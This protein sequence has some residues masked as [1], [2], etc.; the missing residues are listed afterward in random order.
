MALEI[1]DINLGGTLSATTI[2]ATTIVMGSQTLQQIF[3]PSTPSGYLPIS[4]GTVTGQTVFSAGVS[5]NTLSGGTLYGDGSNLTGVGNAVSA[6]LSWKF[7]TTTSNS[8]PGSGSLRYNN[9]TPLS[10]SEI[11][12]DN[13]TE[14]GIDA[15]V[16]LD[17][18]KSGAQIYVQQRDDSSKATLFNVTGDSIDNTGWFSI[19]V[20]VFSDTGGGVPQ[21]NKGCIFIAVLHTSTSGTGT[22]T[23]VQPGSNILTG[24]SAASP[25]I[26]VVD[27][28]S[29]NSVAA[30]GASSFTTLSATTFI[31]G[32]TNLY[33][34]F[35]T[36][37]PGGASTYVQPGTNITTGGTSSEPIINLVDSPSVNNITFSGTAI[38]GTVQAGAGTFTSLSATTLSGGT[39]LSGSTN[40]Y[41][42][43]ATIPDQNDITR[44]QPGS[45]IIT[46]GTVNLPTVSVVASPSFNS[47]TASGASSFTTLSATTFI[48]GSTNL[49]SIFQSIGNADQDPYLNLSGGTVTGNTVFTQGL[50]ASTF[51]AGTINLLGQL[52]GADGATFSTL[53]GTNIFSGSVN[54][55]TYFNTINAQLVTKA[56]DSGDT[57]TGQVNAPSLSATTLSGGTIFSGNT[58]LQT[59]FNLFGAA[60]ATKAN[61]SAATFTGQV[62]IPTLSA[63]TLSANTSVFISSIKYPVSPVAGYL[64]TSDASGNATWQANPTSGSGTTKLDMQS[65]STANTI[66]V[67]TTLVDLVTL[68]AKNLG[69][70]ATTYQIFYNAN[71]NNN[72]AAGN[73]TLRVIVNSTEIINARTIYTNSTTQMASFRRNA[74]SIAFITGVTNGDT[75]KIQ[76][77]AQTGTASVSG[78]TL[79]IIGTLTTNLV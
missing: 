17:R 27:S 54:L 24:G 36:G 52:T 72:N 25:I 32:N 68:T 7:S 48:S 3:A 50:T 4:G 53:S 1:D 37:G 23:Y 9:S 10:I 67:T 20:S 65:I 62:N 46:G 66:S 71:F 75:I 2:S 6:N 61:L 47:V 74:S 63:T 34:I 35:S 21:N 16:I 29:F 55:Q 5:A 22:S 42:I 77:S 28:P 70:S 12:I 14:N 13:I 31:S 58:N 64:L 11:Y 79:S 51:S 44:V 33:D 40:L 19:P 78:R 49:Y 56:N 8:D 57:F 39:I 60:N 15:K 41:S 73:T 69:S 26:S 18:I 59:T 76:M 45:N 43:F 38:G 30:S